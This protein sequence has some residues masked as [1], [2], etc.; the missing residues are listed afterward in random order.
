MFLRAIRDF[1]MEELN[2]NVWGLGDNF[3]S[4][5]TDDME[6]GC[7]HGGVMKVRP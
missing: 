1:K 3:Q 6:E 4:S 7:R 2:D 5:V